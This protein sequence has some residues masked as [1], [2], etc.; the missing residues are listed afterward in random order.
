M[1]YGVE[2]GLR[3]LMYAIIVKFTLLAILGHGEAVS[4]DRFATMAEC[5]AV[6][7]EMT[8]GISRVL[9][10]QHG[11]LIIQSHCGLAIELGGQPIL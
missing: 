10:A 3:G 8:E 9:K 7:A 11:P 2:A 1:A 4:D 5:E 6:R